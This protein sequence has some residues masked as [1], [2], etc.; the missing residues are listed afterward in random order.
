MEVS[1]PTTA[2]AVFHQPS[3]EPISTARGNLAGS[4]AGL[5]LGALA[6][7]GGGGGHGT[8]HGDRHCGQRLC[9]ARASCTS[10]AGGDDDGLGSSLMPTSVGSAST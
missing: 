6:V 10:S 4:T 1:I 3:V 7:K 8:T 5:V 2:D 9:A